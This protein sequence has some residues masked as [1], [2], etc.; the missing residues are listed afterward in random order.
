MNSRLRLVA[1]ARIGQVE[2]ILVHQHRLVAQPLLPRFL[3][4]VLPDLPAELARVRREVEPL[5]LAPELDAFDRSRHGSETFQ[6]HFGA[7]FPIIERLALRGQRA[8]A[9]FREPLREE[10]VRGARSERKQAPDARLPRARLAG[11][12]QALAVA[13]V[14]E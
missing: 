13:D 3:V 9:R 12:Q 6:E 8:D 1:R 11:L 10:P 5:C 14:A 4:D 7:A 2:T